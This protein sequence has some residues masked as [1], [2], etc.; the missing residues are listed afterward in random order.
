MSG[1]WILV[2]DRAKARLFDLQRVAEPDGHRHPVLAEIGGF[3]EPEGRLRP[4]DLESDRPP[5]THDRF[6]HASHAIEPHTTPEDKERARF[7]RSLVEVLEDGRLAG[8]FGSLVIVAT[9]RFLGALNAEM[10]PPLRRCVT[11]EV[12]KE[13]VDADA[14]TLL[15]AI[16]A[17]GA[18]GATSH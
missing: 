9:P 11:A 8:R 6:G 12:A 10:A 16:G 3:S 14:S 13:L 15:E 5:A 4:R 7:A 18:T 2:A 1:T 17:T